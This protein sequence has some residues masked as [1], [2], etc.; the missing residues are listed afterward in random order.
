MKKTLLS[1]LL[2]FT[3]CNVQQQDKIIVKNVNG[4]VAFAVEIAD[5]VEERA[6]GLMERQ[7]LDDNRGMFFIFPNQDNLTFWMKNTYLPLDIIFIDQDWRIVKIAR[8]A[9]PC[10]KGE[11][12]YYRSEVLA[13]YVLEINAGLSD[14]KDIKEGD[15]VSLIHS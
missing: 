6:V 1:L 7:K 10:L 12:P 13:Q 4:E 9:Q 15:Q 14:A 5:S 3:G 8:N 11:C 2:L